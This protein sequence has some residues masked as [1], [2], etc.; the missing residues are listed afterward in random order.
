[1]L[2]ICIDSFVSRARCIHSLI[3]IETCC[4]NSAT[5]MYINIYAFM[6]IKST[7]TAKYSEFQILIFLYFLY[8][9]E[10][11]LSLSLVIFTVGFSLF[12]QFLSTIFAF[13]IRF[14]F[15]SF[16]SFSFFF[17]FLSFHSIKISFLFTKIPYITDVIDVCM[18]Y[19]KKKQK[20]ITHKLNYAMTFTMVTIIA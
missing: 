9:S 13:V 4:Y 19:V 12:N 20:K 15:K 11:S 14:S 17:S 8:Q 3:F 6:E 2:K 10:L 5:H 1:M 7:L 18:K 16:Y